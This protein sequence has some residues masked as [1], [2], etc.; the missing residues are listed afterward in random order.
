MKEFKEWWDEQEIFCG[1]G[2]M[3]AAELAWNE[4]NRLTVDYVHD[5]VLDGCETA[6]ECLDQ[7]LMYSMLIN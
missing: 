4:A 6:E 2:G 5:V 1:E 3:E 7:V